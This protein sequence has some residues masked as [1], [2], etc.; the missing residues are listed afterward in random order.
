MRF[1]SRENRLMWLGAAVGLLTDLGVSIAVVYVVAVLIDSGISIPIVD[2]LAELG[3]EDIEWI[4]IAFV[5]IQ[6]MKVLVWARGA[7]S[8]ILVFRLYQ[9][10]YLID[11]FL[12]AITKAE[13]PEPESGWS[14]SPQ[15]YFDEVL[16]DDSLECQKRMEAAYWLAVLQFPTSVGRYWEGVRLEVIM[17][18]A[19]EKYRGQFEF[20]RG[21][22]AADQPR[23]Q[24]ATDDDISEE[25]EKHF[26]SLVQLVQMKCQYAGSIAED[27]VDDHDRER[28]EQ[29]ITTALGHANEIGDEFY[30]SAALHSIS[31]VLIKAGHFERASELIEQISD[32]QIREMAEEALAESQGPGDLII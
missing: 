7:I 4:L 9:R 13:L 18:Q 27:I 28:V 8:N 32:D 19:I 20:L 17:Q 3:I 6:I 31:E 25:E 16:V 22:P 1:E 21:R 26:A 15:N 10:E 24:A 12:D 2:V 14:V 11:L 29:F 5:G 30:Q 23:E